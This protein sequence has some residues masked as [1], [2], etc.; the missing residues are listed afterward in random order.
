MVDFEV[1]PP[2]ATLDRHMMTYEL[3]GHDGDGNDN[4][5]RFDE[6][7][8]V[9]IDV[10]WLPQLDRNTWGTTFTTQDELETYA[11]QLIPVVADVNFDRTQVRPIEADANSDNLVGP[12]DGNA[13]EA[14]RPTSG[15]LTTSEENFR[16]FQPGMPTMD[17]LTDINRPQLL[18]RRRHW[19]SWLLENCDRWQDPRTVRP[20]EIVKSSI[21][22]VQTKHDAGGYIVFFVTIPKDGFDDEETNLSMAFPENNDMDALGFL[23]RLPSLSEQEYNPARANFWN[24]DARNRSKE[25]LQEDWQRWNFINTRKGNTKIKQIPMDIVIQREVTYTP[26]TFTESTVG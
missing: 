11:R 8:L 17:V 20:M 9:S 22:R 18:F 23:G 26:E 2:M 21:P 25:Q 6:R 14:G 4:G 5:L 12:G 16:L 24:S 1:V 15:Q 13:N 19:F 3:F 7:C 10:F